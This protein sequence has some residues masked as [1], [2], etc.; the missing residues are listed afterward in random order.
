VRSGFQI[1]KQKKLEKV[2]QELLFQHVPSG[3]GCREKGSVLPGRIRRDAVPSRSS[4]LQ[5]RQEGIDV[6]FR[7]VRSDM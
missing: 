3:M 7:R 4:V 1:Q 6:S 2:F 5:Q